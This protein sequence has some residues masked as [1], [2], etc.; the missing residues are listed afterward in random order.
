MNLKT[1][2]NKYYQHFLLFVMLI[3]FVGIGSFYVTEGLTLK[4]LKPIKSR[5]KF[6]EQ[7]YKDEEGNLEPCHREIKSLN[8]C[9]DIQ[10]KKRK[11]AAFKQ[12]E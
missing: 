2:F 3:L 6:G 12:S 10:A 11:M 9:K 7:A 1:V 4:K 5:P 8:L